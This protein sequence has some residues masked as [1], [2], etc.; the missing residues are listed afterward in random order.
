VT[1]PWALDEALVAENARVMLDRAGS[2]VPAQVAAECRAYDA[3]RTA[4]FADP[5]RALAGDK[6][7][8]H[9]SFGLPGVEELLTPVLLA[10]SAE[11][12]RYIADR[13]AVLTR[14]GVRRMLHLPADTSPNAD[15][16]VDTPRPEAPLT[17]E[18]W[19]E[20]RRIV[21]H[22]LVQHGRMSPHRAGI[23]AAAIVGDGMTGPESP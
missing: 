21:T 13:G 23:I 1:R 7:G 11:V 20:V 5:V 3:L 15:E 14:A 10:A 9:L 16:P 18:Q 17:R 4:Y 12:L 22:A 8:G 6:G 2:V 19:A